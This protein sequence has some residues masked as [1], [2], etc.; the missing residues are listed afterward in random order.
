MLA[1]VREAAQLMAVTVHVLTARN[2]NE[3]DNG[4]ADIA[5][6]Q[7]DGLLVMSDPIVI[8]ER[9]RLVALAARH[10]IP[11]IYQTREL[12]VAG[13]LM[14]YG[15]NI[16]GLYHQLSTIAG[17]VLKGVKP[18][19]I[20]VEQPTKYELVIN[21][22]AAKSIGLAIAPSLLARAHEVIE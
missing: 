19:D 1:N 13:G 3:I 4:F 22:K 11:A 12:P 15:S 2:R 10:S 21:L 9:A 16:S 5:R 6:R 17:R 8:S 7:V 14:S 20:P 18:T